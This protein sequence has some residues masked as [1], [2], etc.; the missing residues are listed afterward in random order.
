MSPSCRSSSP[1]WGNPGLAGGRE[2]VGAVGAACVLETALHEPVGGAGRE[3][4]QVAQPLFHRALLQ[5]FEQSVPAS[6]PPAF[7]ARV[8]A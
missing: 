2:H 4:H 6:V 5:V 7:I 1:A 3:E 8:D